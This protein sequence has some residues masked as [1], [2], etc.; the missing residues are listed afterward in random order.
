[1]EPEG[2]QGK[3]CDGE[4]LHHACLPF[5]PPDDPVRAHYLDG[6]TV[7]RFINATVK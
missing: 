3:K 7:D 5:P 2:W 6:H 4:N 1:M